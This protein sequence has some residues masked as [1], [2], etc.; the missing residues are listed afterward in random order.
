MSSP[1][2]PIRRRRPPIPADRIFDPWEPDQHNVPK[3]RPRLS[4]VQLL[5]LLLIRR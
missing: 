5:A 3:E 1:F 2:H 4:E